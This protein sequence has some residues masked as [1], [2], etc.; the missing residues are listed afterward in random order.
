MRLHLD[1]LVDLE[2]PKPGHVRNSLPMIILRNPIKR[3]SR[4]DP[5]HLT[6]EP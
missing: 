3:P 1:H 5:L 4:T 6:G 2:V